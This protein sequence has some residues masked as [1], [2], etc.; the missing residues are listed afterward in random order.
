M[1]T[2]DFDMEESESKKTQR[3]HRRKQEN[4]GFKEQEQGVTITDETVARDVSFTDLLFTRE[5]STEKLL[6]YTRQYQLLAGVIF[7]NPCQFPDGKGSF[8]KQRINHYLPLIQETLNNLRGVLD[9]VITMQVGEDQ[10]PIEEINWIPKATK[11]S[12]E[13]INQALSSCSLQYW[14]EATERYTATVENY[15]VELAERYINALEGTLDDLEF[16]LSLS[17]DVDLSITEANSTTRIAAWVLDRTIGTNTTTQREENADDQA[18]GFFEKSPMRHINEAEHTDLYKGVVKITSFWKTQSGEIVS[19]KGTGALVGN[20][21]TVMTAAHLVVKRGRRLCAAQIHVGLNTENH[22]Q[23]TTTHVV[24]PWSYFRSYD[25]AFDIA[26]IRITI[27]DSKISRGLEPLKWRETPLQRPL[28]IQVVGY[29]GYTSGKWSEPSGPRNTDMQSSEWKPRAVEEMEKSRQGVLLHEASTYNGS[30]GSPIFQL[31]NNKKK[32]GPIIAV[33]SSR[34]K[35]GNQK[36]NVAVTLDKEFKN[37]DTMGKMLEMFANQQSTSS[38]VN[39][40][41]SSVYC[42]NINNAGKSFS[43]FQLFQKW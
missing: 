31:S 28:Q 38:D 9:I 5:S 26:L 19:S 25:P 29:P 8:R 24:C 17:L 23:L 4:R 27:P 39:E 21:N 1:G 36:K 42:M 16:T 22:F 34:R 3:Q 10:Q 30:S 32:R 41:G 35:Y 13:L 12:L 37:P 6:L 18:E 40:D 33:H 7:G 2:E 20:G 15:G 43:R 11:S 14:S